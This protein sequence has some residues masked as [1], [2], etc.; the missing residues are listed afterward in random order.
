MI[1]IEQ[2]SELVPISLLETRYKVKTMSVFSETSYKQVT[3]CI[4]GGMCV[5]FK[6][7]I[8]KEPGKVLVH[9]LNGDDRIL[10]LHIH[11]NSV[12]N[13]TY[14]T[15]EDV[16]VGVAKGCNLSTEFEFIGFVGKLED[17]VVK[18]NKFKEKVKE[19][20]EKVLP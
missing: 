12:G 19:A 18:V 16:G 6:C 11:I 20:Q 1:Y 7:T 13:I 9:V 3:G 15:D 14:S 8:I 2:L 17:F 4:I 5:S 10:T